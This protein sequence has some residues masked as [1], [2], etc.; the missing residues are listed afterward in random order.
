MADEVFVVKICQ[1]QLLDNAAAGTF[2]ARFQYEREI[3][4]SSF[5][6]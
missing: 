5:F 1:P 2:K 6:Y 4:H 3:K